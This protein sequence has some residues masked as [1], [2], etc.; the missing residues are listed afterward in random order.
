MM[1]AAFLLAGILSQAPQ[2]QPQ[3]WQAPRYHWAS[4][5]DRNQ[6]DPTAP[7]KIGNIWHVFVDVGRAVTPPASPTP[8]HPDT[9]SGS[10][11][12]A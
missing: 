8:R 9:P 3:P 7:I 1:A 11:A 5:L 6:G 10:L 4:K 2:P 12:L